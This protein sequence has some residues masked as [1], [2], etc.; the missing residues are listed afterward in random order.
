VTPVFL[1]TLIPLLFLLGMVK[2][3]H[4]TLLAFFAWGLTAFMGA[5]R[6][7]TQ[8]VAAQWVGAPD[9]SVHAAPVVEELLKT[10]PLV[11]FLLRP[12]TEKR[13]L[14]VYYA[15]A[16]GIGFSIIENYLYLSRQSGADETIPYMILRSA[17][18]SLMHGMTAAVVGMGISFLQEFRVFVLPITFGLLSAAIT[19]HSLYNLTVESPG[20]RSLAVLLPLSL[21]LLSHPIVASLYPKSDDTAQG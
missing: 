11:Y 15:M 14:I 10:L 6:L 16:S 5:L 2:N 9:L 19:G 12:R 13:Y 18:T 4:R 8:L 21:Y 17:S 1:G 7:N 20:F 3:E